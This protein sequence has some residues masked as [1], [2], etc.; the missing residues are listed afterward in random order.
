MAHISVA[1]VNPL[2]PFADP[3]RHRFDSTHPQ[4][5]K[6]LKDSVDHHGREHLTGVLQQIHREIHQT[7]LG[8]TTKI[9]AHIII[10]RNH[11]QPYRQVEVLCGRPYRIEILVAE[12]LALFRYGC[13]EYISTPQ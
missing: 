1:V 9:T 8:I 5:W 3:S 6:A 10:V 13:D 11:V 7:G 2:E 12:A 4:T